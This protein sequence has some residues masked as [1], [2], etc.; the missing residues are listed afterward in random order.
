MSTVYYGIMAYLPSTACN[1]L[2][3]SSLL[4]TQSTIRHM[5]SNLLP[6]PRAYWCSLTLLFAGTVHL[7]LIITFAP[8]G[9]CTYDTS[10][11]LWFLCASSLPLC[12]ARKLAVLA[13]VLCNTQGLLLLIN[14]CTKGTCI[15][16]TMVVCSTRC[17]PCAKLAVRLGW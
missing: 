6:A 10:I 16:N 1:S 2:K 8:N 9:V 12:V 15:H 14:F 5:A 4:F 7:L 17:F 11:V 3:G 13:Y